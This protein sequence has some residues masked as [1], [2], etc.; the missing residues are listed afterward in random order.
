MEPARGVRVAPR[1]N[2]E[3]PPHPGRIVFYLRIRNP[4]MSLQLQQTGKKNAD[5]PGRYRSARCGHPNPTGW[6]LTSWGSWSQPT[7][8]GASRDNVEVPPH[9]GRTIFNP[10]MR[11]PSI[12]IL[13]RQ[14]GDESGDAP[15]LHRPAGC[16]KRQLYWLVADWLRLMAPA[17]G[18]SCLSGQ[19]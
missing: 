19:R 2:A 3:V 10:R 7:A 13:L 9:P 16:G 6:L 5:P 4:S 15:G 12:H 17:R 18:E 14:A 11:N 8:R 1:A